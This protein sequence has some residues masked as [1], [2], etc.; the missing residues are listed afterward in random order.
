MVGPLGIKAEELTMGAWDYVF[1]GADYD[2]EKCGNIDEESL[3][4][5][6]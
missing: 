6:R 1:L 3:K 4:K 5:M 2:A